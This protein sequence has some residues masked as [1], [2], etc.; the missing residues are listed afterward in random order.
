MQH[1]AEVALRG[2]YRDGA[3]AIGE[4]DGVPREQDRVSR[5]IGFKPSG[6]GQ[7]NRDSSRDGKAGY[8]VAQ[9][10]K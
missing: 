6:I 8:K 9:F 10:E 5:R 1:L 7:R 2:D 4:Q 3:R